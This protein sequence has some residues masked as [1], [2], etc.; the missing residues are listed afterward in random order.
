M[1]TSTNLIAIAAVLF[2]SAVS[3]QAFSG[4]GSGEFRL[5][6]DAQADIRGKGMVNAVD[7]A[8]HKL[9]LSHQ[10][11]PALGWP[12]MKMDFTVA[13]SVDLTAVK[14][15]TAIDFTLEKNKAGGYEI[16][17]IQPIAK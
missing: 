5:A 16:R 9:N 2:M 1:R 10:A 17:S 4:S 8:G 12:A 7:A 13:P 3:T 14:P 15:G 6:A 11:I